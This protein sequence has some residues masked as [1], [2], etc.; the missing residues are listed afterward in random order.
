MLEKANLIPNAPKFL[1][2]KKGWPVADGGAVTEQV[3]ELT[4]E[5]ILADPHQASRLAERALAQARARRDGGAQASA[6]RILGL[7]AHALHDAAAAAAWLRRA[8]GTARRCGNA[9]VEAEARMSY[10]LVLDDLGRS[11]AALREID[12][13]CEGLS[14][15]RLARAGMQRALILRRAGRDD[16]ALAG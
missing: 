7:A 2:K 16:D 5:Q 12:R 3:E 6:E 15:L 1:V 8:I 10:A 9:T 11:A 13:A 14:G 4:G